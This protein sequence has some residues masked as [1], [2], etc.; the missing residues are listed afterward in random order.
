MDPLP[1]M[2][3]GW[4]NTPR[5]WD[6]EVFV[7]S[8]STPELYGKWL[9]KSLWHQQQMQGKD[10]AV[11]INAWNEWAEGAHLEP[12]VDFAR[13]YLE[14]TRDVAQSVGGTIDVSD[15]G[16]DDRVRLASLEDRYAELYQAVAQ[17]QRRLS[18]YLSRAN[19]RLQSL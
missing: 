17:L 9:T 3:T 19:L 14:V 4:D 11:F 12:D 13:R 5:R 2:A 8:G 6:G 15:H 10:S 7:L 1:C 16:Q 18:A